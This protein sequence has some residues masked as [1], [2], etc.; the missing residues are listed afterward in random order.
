MLTFAQRAG[1]TSLHDPR[2]LSRGLTD[3]TRQK[4][5]LVTGVPGKGRGVND[6]Q[7]HFI[8]NLNTGQ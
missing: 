1:I 8:N 2:Y 7:L 3:S 5:F 4:V 6:F